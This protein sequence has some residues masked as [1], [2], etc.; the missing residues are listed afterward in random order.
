[1]CG[2]RAPLTVIVHSLLGDATVLCA[3]VVAG[4]RASIVVNERYADALEHAQRHLLQTDT[5]VWI[6]SPDCPGPD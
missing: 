3:I 5:T 1:M 4:G 2:K 6:C